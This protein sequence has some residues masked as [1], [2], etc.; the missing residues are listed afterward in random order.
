M[1]DVFSD[2]CMMLGERMGSETTSQTQLT[3]LPA[4]TLGVRQADTVLYDENQVCDML[5][6]TTDGVIEEAA[7]LYVNGNLI[8]SVKNRADLSYLLS[9]IL[10]TVKEDEKASSSQFVES[11][12]LYPACIPP[13]AS[14]PVT[15]CGRYSPV[16]TRRLQYRIPGMRA[17]P[18]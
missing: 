9:D 14:C 10:D 3:F 7:G 5:L 6:Q 16:K 11:I 8:G 4:Y 13:I 15:N 17:I 18:K 12:R 1:K 2:A